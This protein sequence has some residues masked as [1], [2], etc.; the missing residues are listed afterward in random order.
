[1][2]NLL[3]KIED[4]YNKYNKDREPREYI[5]PPM[6]A[7]AIKMLNEALE[8]EAKKHNIKF[9]QEYA[10]K[11]CNMEDNKYFTPDIEDIR[12]GYECEIREYNKTDWYKHIVSE[13]DLSFGDNETSLTFIPQYKDNIRVPYLTKEQILAENEGKSW[14]VVKSH[15][16]NL[17]PIDECK[18][19][20]GSKT[21]NYMILKTGTSIKII[22][23]ADEL[24]ASARKVI[25]T[26]PYVIKFDGECIDINEFR[27]ITK[28]Y[29]KINQYV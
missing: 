26:Y 3:S 29:L 20:I 8:E 6:G 2:D 1:M 11:Q 23:V 28:K 27:R 24:S 18:E 15:N 25:R 10:E 9:E 5:W 12:V 16:L 19:V 14:G 13:D 22:M 7:G 4:L 21:N 17:P